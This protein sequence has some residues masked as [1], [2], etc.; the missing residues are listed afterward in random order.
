MRVMFVIGLLAA[1][2]AIPTIRTAKPLDVTISQDSVRVNGT[3]LRSARVGA[4]RF[5][6][7]RAAQKAL[8]KPAAPFAAGLG[9]R[10][11]RWP[12]CGITIQRGW[13]GPEKDELFKIQVWLSDSYDRFADKH[14]G[15]FTGPLIVDGVLIVPDSTLDGLRG[16]LER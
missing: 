4:L 9:V 15:S 5:I 13:R 8:G 1:Q 16:E 6:S 7:L 14:T 2:A 12:D 3:E 10:V 11:Y